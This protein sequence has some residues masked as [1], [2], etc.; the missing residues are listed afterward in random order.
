MLMYR[1]LQVSVL[2]EVMC[3]GRT[4]RRSMSVRKAVGW[5]AMA[6]V[7]QLLHLVMLLHAFPKFFRSLSHAMLASVCA[8]PVYFRLYPSSGTF[9]GNAFL[10]A[11]VYAA[12][13]IPGVVCTALVSVWLLYFNRFLLVFY[14]Y[15]PL[16]T[17]L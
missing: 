15:F 12:R 11:T 1:M 6:E 7:A 8:T 17:R 5:T 13:C 14:V 16:A 10:S 4:V 9:S 2:Y 3:R